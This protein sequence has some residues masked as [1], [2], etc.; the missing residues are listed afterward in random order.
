MHL[1][2]WKTQVVE[3]LSEWDCIFGLYFSPLVPLLLPSLPSPAN[4][5]S[6]LPRIP[7]P[8][9]CPCSSPA[10]RLM[11]PCTAPTS[12]LCISSHCTEGRY[13]LYI[14]LDMVVWN[15]LFYVSLHQ[16][17]LPAGVRNPIFNKCLV[18]MMLEGGVIDIL[19]RPAIYFWL[20]SIH[21]YWKDLVTWEESTV[22]DKDNEH[23]CGWSRIFSCPGSSIP[24]LGQS[25]TDWVPLLNF[26]RK[27]DF[28]DLRPFRHLIRVMSR[29]KDRK[30]KR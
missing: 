29:Q 14:H 16:N 8:C 12:L 11:V 13:Q 19:L 3:F 26:D 1:M 10:P 21:A 22:R 9:Y 17:L 28:W 23:I 24:D 30:T 7:C 5:Q 27:S 15:L 25:L 4:D 20:T 2:V 18:D 6:P